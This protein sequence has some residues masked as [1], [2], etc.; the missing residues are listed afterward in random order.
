MRRVCWLNLRKKVSYFNTKKKY[1]FSANVSLHYSDRPPA[2]SVYHVCQKMLNEQRFAVAFSQ[3]AVS[4]H[5]V[6]TVNW[7]WLNI[8]IISKLALSIKY[9]ISIEIEW[10]FD[11]FGKCRRV[12]DRES[13]RPVWEDKACSIQQQRQKTLSTCLIVSDESNTETRD[14]FE[15]SQNLWQL[16]SL[17]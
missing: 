10:D 14:G 5:E 15:F 6:V 4:S 16:F 8:L 7:S 1:M 13:E 11:Q 9:R 12:D 17:I 3:E 2:F